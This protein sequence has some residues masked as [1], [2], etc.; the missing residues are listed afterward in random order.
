[1]FPTGMCNQCNSKKLNYSYSRSVKSGNQ[2]WELINHRQ[3]SKHDSQNKRRLSQDNK[4]AVLFKYAVFS[5]VNKRAKS[6]PDLY[7]AS[8]RVFDRFQLSAARLARLHLSFIM[9]FEPI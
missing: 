8:W 9:I 4:Y 6:I 5:M 7:V 1:M 2:D 3:C